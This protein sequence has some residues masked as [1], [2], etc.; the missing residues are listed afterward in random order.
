MRLRVRPGETVFI[1][2]GA[3]SFAVQFAKA[4]GARVLATAGS[5]NQEHLPELGVG[6]PL[7]YQAHDVTAA[8]L[9]ASRG[10]GVDCVLDTVRGRAR[11]AQPASGPRV[12]P[13]GVDPRPTRRLLPRVPAQPDDPRH[14]P[15]A[16][17]AAAAAYDA[18][19][20]AET[21]P[22]RDRARAAIG[23]G[24]RSASQARHRPRPAQDCPRN[25]LTSG[26][27]CD[28]GRRSDP[29]PHA[30]VRDAR[31]AHCCRPPLS[32]PLR[33]G[34]RCAVAATLASAQ[35][36][37]RPAGRGNR[38]TE[39]PRDRRKRSDMH[40]GRS[41]LGPRSVKRASDD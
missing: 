34:R 41:R 9:A 35:R 27:R 37:V 5:A 3:G 20:R 33:G 24:R 32:D 29:Q 1:P 18:A 16:P 15:D 14:L 30:L 26:A 10:V 25:R 38:P 19:V 12:R 11:G 40:S 13:G 8:A 31:R 21:G 22:A 2:G 28:C 7:D 39:E 36:V 6:V 4:S 17:T 23:P